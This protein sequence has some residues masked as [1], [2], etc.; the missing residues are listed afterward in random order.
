MTHK[1]IVEALLAAS[2]VPSLYTEPLRLNSNPDLKFPLVAIQDQ[3]SAVI[4]G[5][6]RLTYNI[7]YFDQLED[8][9]SNELAV[10]STAI[11][12]LQ[13]LLSDCQAPVDESNYTI[14][15]F[16]TNLTSLTAGAFITI[17]TFAEITPE[18]DEY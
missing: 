8:D 14:T 3:P 16:T 9:Y 5:Q 6:L 15:T 11:S 7:Y 4:D 17:H 2:P 1:Q 10:K 18:C 12:S 13:Q